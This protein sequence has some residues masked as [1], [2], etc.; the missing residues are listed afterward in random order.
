MESQDFLNLRR[1]VLIP[2]PNFK[3]PIPSE[4]F[5]FSGRDIKKIQKIYGCDYMGFF[6][7]QENGKVYDIF[8]RK[9]E[10]DFEWGY[11][12]YLTYPG[13]IAINASSIFRSGI[14]GILANDGETVLV[15]RH[16]HDFVSD[17]SEDDG[18]FIAIDGGGDYTRI[19]G[20]PK[21]IRITARDG[22]FVFTELVGNN[23]NR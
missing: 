23:K 9:P 13:I 15:S 1:F 5:H 4:G 17:G 18:N 2:E 14:I 21:F 10:Y 7:S 22:K 6:S 20:N 3:L 19:I 12:G 8:Y 11:T 16:R